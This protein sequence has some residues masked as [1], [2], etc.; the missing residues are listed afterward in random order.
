M[1]VPE[2]F[3]FNWCYVEVSK[4]LTPSPSPAGATMYTQVSLSTFQ[5]LD[6]PS[7]PLKRGENKLNFLLPPF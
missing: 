2:T 6:T 4:A 5:G 3:L 7:P 1:A